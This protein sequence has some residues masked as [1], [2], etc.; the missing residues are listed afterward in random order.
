MASLAKSKEAFYLEHSE[1]EISD[2]LEIKWN[3]KEAID[4]KKRKK[5]I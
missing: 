1:I 3:Q 5:N 2:S 4:Y